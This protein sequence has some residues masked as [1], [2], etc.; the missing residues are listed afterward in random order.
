MNNS[1]NFQNPAF[2]E[3]FD[4]I[5][6]RMPAITFY[7]IIIVYSVTAALNCFFIPLPLYLSIP[8]ALALQFGRF[9]IVFMDFLNPTGTRSA[10][11]PL[12]AAVAT[13]IALA[14][15]GFSIQ[16]I[17]WTGAKFW[18][19]FLFGG[20]V[21]SF[22]YL[23][24]VNFIS[25]G[26]EAFGMGNRHKPQGAASASQVRTMVQPEP[27]AV[28]QQ[29][30]QQPAQVQQANQAEPRRYVFA[31]N[32]VHHHNGT[33]NQGATEQARAQVQHL[34]SHAR[35]VN[36]PSITQPLLTQPLGRTNSKLIK[37]CEHCA[38]TYQAKVIWQRF[39]SP[40]CKQAHHAAQHGGQ[41]FS[42]KRYHRVKA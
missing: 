3:I 19:V 39:C 32:G 34:G 5:T 40:G 11:P 14:E 30:Q 41:Q 31:P 13:I 20:A 35:V 7:G 4:G 33:T 37:D 1:N 25:K 12:I 18:S 16:D 23:L 36:N 38:K 8:A 15:L 10:W 24:E 21:I 27:Q 29:P 28:A 9:A 2:A 17:G 22:G 26:A 6:A 42:P